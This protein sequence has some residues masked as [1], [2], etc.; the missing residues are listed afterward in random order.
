M[1]ATS[2]VIQFLGHSDA[3]WQAAF[4]PDGKMVLTA[5]DDRTARLWMPLPGRSCA[6]SVA[7]PTESTARSSRRWQDGAHHQR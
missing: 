2:G 1:P 7:T 3:V 6:A 4:S 5:S